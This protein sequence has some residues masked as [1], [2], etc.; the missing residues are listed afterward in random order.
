MCGCTEQS[1]CVR[2]VMAPMPCSWTDAR[3]DLCTECAVGI[4]NDPPP[5]DSLAAAELQIRVLRTMLLDQ[6]QF[7]SLMVQTALSDEQPR[8]IVP[9]VDFVR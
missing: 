1:A 5:V 9:D 3:E 2:D 7:T 8:I 6:I 4:F